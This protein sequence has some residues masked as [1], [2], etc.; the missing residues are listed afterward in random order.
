MYS[1]AGQPRGEPTGGNEARN[2]QKQGAFFSASHIHEGFKLKP[3]LEP[4]FRANCLS[5]VEAEPG[6][7]SGA[8]GGLRDETLSIRRRSPCSSA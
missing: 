8:A 7:H 1:K 2:I 3:K 6:K 4:N 5:G